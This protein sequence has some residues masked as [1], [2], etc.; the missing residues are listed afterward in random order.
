MPSLCLI[1]LQCKIEKTQSSVSYDFYKASRRIKQ[2]KPPNLT[3]G[4][5]S[6]GSRHE[7]PIVSDNGSLGDKGPASVHKWAETGRV[8]NWSGALCPYRTPLPPAG[9][10]DSCPGPAKGPRHW[11]KTDPSPLSPTNF[12]SEN[13]IPLL[14]TGL[15]LALPAAGPYGLS[16]INYYTS[17]CSGDWGALGRAIPTQTVPFPL[18]Q[19]TQCGLRAHGGWQVVPQRGKGPLP[20]PSLY[21]LEKARMVTRLVWGSREGEEEQPEVWERPPLAQG[22][23]PELCPLVC[24]SRSS[25]LKDKSSPTTPC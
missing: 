19:E 8:A 1:F 2:K 13:F 7:R 12:P 14:G 9:C 23:P 22:I 25:F 18:G 21:Y 5:G 24:D 17:S 15:V 20:E 16:H 11:V 6:R 3:L 4:P 10:L